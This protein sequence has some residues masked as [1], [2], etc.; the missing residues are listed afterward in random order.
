MELQVQ[1]RAGGR[2]LSYRNTEGP[3]QAGQRQGGGQQCGG[4]EASEGLAC[5]G[6]VG[7]SG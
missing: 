3:P 5:L 1:V 2:P 6:L 7:K 4:S